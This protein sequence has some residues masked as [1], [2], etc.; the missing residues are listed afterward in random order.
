M[1][2]IQVVEPLR[3]YSRAARLALHTAP[4]QAEIKGGNNKIVTSSAV[5]V[6]PTAALQQRGNGQIWKNSA[7]RGERMWRSERPPA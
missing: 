2:E 4:K 5:A 6:L 3:G 7:F 1:K